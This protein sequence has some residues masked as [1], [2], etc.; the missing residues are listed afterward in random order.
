LTVP[1]SASKLRSTSSNCPAIAGT[2]QRAAVAG[3]V[4]TRSSRSGS[5]ARSRGPQG[6]RADLQRLFTLSMWPAG[7]SRA[8]D[9]DGVRVRLQ[10][11]TPG[12]DVVYEREWDADMAD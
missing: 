2:A 9:Q 3:R 12:R 11:T 8:C 10:L 6:S 5:I 7:F 1:S 4:Q